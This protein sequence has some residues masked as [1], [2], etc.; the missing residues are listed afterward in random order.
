MAIRIAI[1]EY[2]A[3]LAPVNGHSGSGKVERKTY[4]DGNEAMRARYR[5]NDSRA[6]ELELYIN[7]RSV[8]IL[9]RS[10]K[11]AELMLDSCNGDTVPEVKTGHKVE[12]WS[13]VDVIAAGQFAED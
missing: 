9:N 4:D 3:K 7:E 6:S 2:E 8:G 10:K 13:G 5:E 11:K 1:L 12:L